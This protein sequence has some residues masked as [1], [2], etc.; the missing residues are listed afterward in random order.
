MIVYGGQM[1]RC[2]TVLTTLLNVDDVPVSAHNLE[3]IDTIHFGGQ[4]HGRQFLLVQH[5]GFHAKREQTLERLQRIVFDRLV[6]RRIASQ[7]LD[8]QICV[9]SEYHKHNPYRSGTKVRGGGHVVRTHRHA[10]P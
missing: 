7:V 9:E 3:R 1:E 6:Q 5:A 2:P 4:M 10:A 8:V